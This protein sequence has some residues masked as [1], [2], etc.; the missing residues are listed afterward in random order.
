[1]K[2]MFS[3]IFGLLHMQGICQNMTCSE[4]DKYVLNDSLINRFIR[5][6]KSQFDGFSPEIKASS[7]KII[8]K[9]KEMNAY[10]TDDAGC[11]IIP[12]AYLILKIRRLY[13]WKDTL[14]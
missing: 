3:L 10:L 13:N 4:A 5:D 8:R 11:I 9:E 7:V 2:L 1:M 6:Y 12:E 14:T